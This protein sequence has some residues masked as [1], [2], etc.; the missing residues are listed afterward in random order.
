ML[1]LFLFVHVRLNVPELFG[2]ALTKYWPL[3]IMGIA[4]VGIGLSE[5]FSRRGLKV[6]SQPLQRTGV[7]MP[8]LP[9]LAFWISPPQA[10]HDLLIRAMPGLQPSL[11]PLMK[12][13]ANFGHYAIIW[14]SLGLL[15]SWVA[16]INRSFRFALLAALAGNFGIWALLYNADL[17]FFSHPQLWMIPLAL[18]LL[19]SE[20][21]NRQ[22]LGPQKSNAL[23]YLGLI[24][25]YVSST[26][27]MFLAWGENAYLPLA[28]AGLSILGVLAGILLRVTA[29]L[30][31]G[32]S[33]L[34]VVVFSMIWH[35]AVDGRQMWLWWACGIG[36][37]ALIFAL[38]AVFE[39]RR[40][41]VL[42]LI[43]DI[44]SWE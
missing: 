39:K 31:L 4:F 32:T 13:E 42:K 11:E 38:F 24:L 43:E 19:V 12:H 16:S 2:G 10:V 18:I 6:L 25:I 20:H 41:D 36:L 44:K 23:R 8:L 22:E 34:F 40:E 21:I 15:Y 28:L 14:F 35:A 9:L 27:D 3:A 29:F 1:L 7:F 17:S 37:G 33:F 5:F 30:Y 26:A